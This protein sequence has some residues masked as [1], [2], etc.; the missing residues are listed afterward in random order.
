MG[1]LLHKA[2]IPFEIY[3]R[4][5]DIKPL[6]KA[7]PEEYLPSLSLPFSIIASSRIR[8]IV[9]GQFFMC[10][11]PTK[12]TSEHSFTY[13]FC[14]QGSSMFLNSTTASFFKQCGIYDEF[15]SI[16]KYASNILMCT[17]D[18]KVDFTM[19]FAQ[20]ETE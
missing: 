6:G 16:G 20:H 10:L 14:S 2:G 4:A 12:S 13:F 8:N 15:V 17:E 1:M 18:R 3:E 19:E 5:T 9:K 11:V 7:Q